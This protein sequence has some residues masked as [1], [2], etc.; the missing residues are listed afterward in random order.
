MNFSES[1]WWETNRYVERWVTRYFVWEET[2]CYTGMDN[3]HFIT[4]VSMHIVIISVVGYNFHLSTAREIPRPLVNNSRYCMLTHVIRYIYYMDISWPKSTFGLC[5]D[6]QLHSMVW[7]LWGR[8]IL[9][10][11]F[12]NFVK[13]ILWNLKIFWQKLLNLSFQNSV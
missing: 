3:K 10:L 13:I 11:N 2:R 1:P 7:L 5:S 4:L 8:L 12:F 6:L 9:L